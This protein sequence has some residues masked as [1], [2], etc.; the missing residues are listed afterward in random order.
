MVSAARAAGTRAASRCYR[1]H[2]ANVV[3]QPTQAAQLA[4]VRAV[5]VG[6]RLVLGVVSVPRANVH[7]QRRLRW[8]NGEDVFKPLSVVQMHLRCIHLNFH[9]RLATQ[10]PPPSSLP[11]RHAS[12]AK[13]CEAMLS[14]TNTNGRLS[15]ARTSG[16]GR[17]EAEAGQKLLYCSWLRS[18]QVCG[19]A[20]GVE[21]IRLALVR[22]RIPMG[23]S[24]CRWSRRP[25]DAPL[26]KEP[27]HVA[28]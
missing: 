1:R 9:L 26:E 16:S 5:R 25:R 24:P 15:S 8:H 23:V 19:I 18:M 17:N 12:A 10:S 6:I 14:P 22:V 7:D 11:P 27:L 2:H 28:H 3:P 21:V 4:H 20:A 13:T